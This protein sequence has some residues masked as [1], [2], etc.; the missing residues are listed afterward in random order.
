MRQGKDD[1]D[2]VKSQPWRDQETFHPGASVFR[3]LSRPSL[4]HSDAAQILMILT[5]CII[6]GL[7]HLGLHRLATVG[8]C[9]CFCV[10]FGMH[11]ASSSPMCPSARFCFHTHTHTLGNCVCVCVCVCV[12]RMSWATIFSGLKAGNRRFGE[13]DIF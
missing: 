11:A 3:K 5:G 9:V 10:F 1:E 12:L 6:A 8:E 7:H 4:V 13:L 2:A